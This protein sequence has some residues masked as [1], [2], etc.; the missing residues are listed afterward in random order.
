MCSITLDLR[1]RLALQELEK[2][3]R[4]SFDL[5]AFCF[6]EQLA[7]IQDPARFKIADCSRRAGKTVGIAADLINTAQMFP[8]LASLYITLSRL[9]AKRILWRDLCA[10]NSEHG[11]GFKTNE[12][13]LT[14]T[15]PNG[16]IIYLSGAKDKTEIEKYRGFPLKKIYIDEA[17][18]FRPYIAELVDDV[19]AKS[20][21]DYNGSLSLTGTP[22]PI[23]VG[24]FHDCVNNPQWSRHSWTM[25]Q[26]PWIKAKSGREPMDLALED[27]KRMGVSLDDPRIQ[28]ECFGKWSIDH[29]SLVFKY[30]EGRDHYDALPEAR[31]W[32]YVIGVDLGFDDADAIAV[33]GWAEHAPQAYLIHEDVARKQGITELAAKLERLIRQY[34]PVAVVLDTGG[35][36]KKIAEEIR[37]R[38]SL[39]IRAAEKARK[40]E[41]IELLNDAMRTARFFAKRDS[42]FAQDA[43][44]VEFD[45]DKSNGDRMVISE[46]YHS[47]ICDA[48]LYA[49]RESQHWLHEPAIVLPKV[50]S[51]EWQAAQETAIIVDLEQALRHDKDDPNE[52]PM[53]EG[54]DDV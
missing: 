3:R 45:R 19:L 31:R 41:Y 6:P 7:F 54:F 50:G 16:H 15:A 52:W 29:T 40:F 30:D 37:K 53:P 24:Y 5:K 35:L 4:T 22:P 26:N 51:K 12:S 25:F 14:M 32:E 23:P 39:P 13:E 20:L 46:A 48:V 38:Y 33:V 34:N 43:R 1:S 18:S 47:D 11:L 21:Y 42:V 8:K 49:F 27:C 17:Q 10:I 36:G 28:R 44:L 2:R 9:N